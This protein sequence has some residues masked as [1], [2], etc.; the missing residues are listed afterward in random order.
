MRKQKELKELID[1]IL[2]PDR[3]NL[4]GLF[5]VLT[6]K[7]QAPTRLSPVFVKGGITHD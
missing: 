6:G 3:L 4:S 2:R 5:F 7:C 1:S